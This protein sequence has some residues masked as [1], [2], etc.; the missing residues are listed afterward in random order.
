[1][2]YLTYIA[3]FAVVIIVF[4]ILYKIFRFIISILLIGLFLIFAYFT[5]PT[6]EQHRE[7]VK[8][9]AVRIDASLKNKKVVRENYYVFSIT[10]LNHR[11]EHRVIG[12]GA[13]TKVFIF[14]NP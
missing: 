5:N 7:A 11:D 3:V 2:E 8:Q 13:F 9:K 10:K 14:A 6:D 1:M 12:A 4:I